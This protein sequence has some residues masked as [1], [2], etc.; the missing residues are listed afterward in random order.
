ML[1]DSLVEFKKSAIYHIGN[2][3]TD[4]RLVMQG[5]PVSPSINGKQMDVLMLLRHALFILSAQDMT[6]MITN[7]SRM[8]REGISTCTH[9]QINFN[10]GSMV[11]E[12]I[13]Y[14]VTTQATE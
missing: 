3:F 12:V 8:F 10:T 14:C 6:I 13:W 7:S 5:T 2:I 4:G 9:N 1:G 11:I